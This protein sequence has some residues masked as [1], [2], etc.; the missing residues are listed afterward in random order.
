MQIQNPVQCGGTGQGAGSVLASGYNIEIDIT[1]NEIAPTWA[2]LRSGISS[3]SHT[4]NDVI[5]KLDYIE[6]NGW[7]FTEIIGAQYIVKV[8]GDRISGDPAQDFIFQRA[9]KIGCQRKTNCR[10]TDP[11]KN[12]VQSVATIANISLPAGKASQRAAFTFEIHFNG[13]PFYIPYVPEP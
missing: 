4:T 6:G 9:L 10:I 5:E 3:F 11:D 2:S 12:I 7:A 8:A 13:E 1:P